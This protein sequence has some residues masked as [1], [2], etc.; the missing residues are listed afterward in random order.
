[1]VQLL[2]RELHAH[3]KHEQRYPE[4]GNRTDRLFVR[5]DAGTIRT[6]DK[7]RNKITEQDRQT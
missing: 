1:M 2:Q 5:D 3:G 7:T 6:D 4:I